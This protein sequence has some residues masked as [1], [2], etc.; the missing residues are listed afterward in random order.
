MQFTYLTDRI[1][2]KDWLNTTR[3]TW[4]LHC[5]IDLHSHANSTFNNLWPFKLIFLAQLGAAMDYMCTKFG[6][7][8]S[9]CFAFRVRTDTHTDP[10]TK[11]QMPLITLPTHR[12]LLAWLT[13][14]RIHVS[15]LLWM[16]A[17]HISKTCVLILREKGKK[18]TGRGHG[19]VD[20]ASV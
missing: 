11:S 6:V 8:S 20:M 10:H 1:H 4:N 15:W 14:A 18:Y 9:S 13:T 5:R 3:K 2:T 7:D 16:P 19:S 17:K 12:L